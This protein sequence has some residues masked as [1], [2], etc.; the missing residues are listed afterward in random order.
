MDSV[1]STRKP[2][3]TPEARQLALQALGTVFTRN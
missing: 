2:A 3:V 1:Q